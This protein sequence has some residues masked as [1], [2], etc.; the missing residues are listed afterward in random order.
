MSIDESYMYVCTNYVHTYVSYA[1]I[2]GTR[3]NACWRC[4]KYIEIFEMSARYPYY[5]YLRLGEYVSVPRS[6][7][8]ISE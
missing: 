8:Y 5:T 2:A 1:H 7:L 3:V 4:C 6:Y